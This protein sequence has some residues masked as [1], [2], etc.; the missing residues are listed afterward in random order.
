MS[1]EKH[2]TTTTSDNP[3]VNTTVVNTEI[4]NKVPSPTGNHDHIET[5]SVEIVESGNVSDDSVASAD[6]FVPEPNLNC[7]I[8]TSQHLLMQ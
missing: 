4:N 2:V 5:V 7:R 8:P 1:H 3:A 6:Y